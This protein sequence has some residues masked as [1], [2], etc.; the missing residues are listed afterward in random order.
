MLF[1]Q[2]I[3]MMCNLIR[4]NSGG[5]ECCSEH[6]LLNGLTATQKAEGFFFVFIP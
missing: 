4:L 2:A 5:H 3:H 1:T 6:V